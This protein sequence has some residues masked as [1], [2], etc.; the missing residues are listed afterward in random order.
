MVGLRDEAC[1][2][3]PPFVA[4]WPVPV[5]ERS[6]PFGRCKQI[7]STRQQHVKKSRPSFISRATTRPLVMK[8]E[9]EFFQALSQL[10]LF[11]LRSIISGQ[12]CTRH[13]S[14]GRVRHPRHQQ[15]NDAQQAQTG[16]EPRPRPK[17][18]STSPCM[19]TAANVM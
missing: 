15:H 6:S 18:S 12:H 11:D 9:H 2:L 19:A 14:S 1:S 17:D 10:P 5:E 8:F 13:N 16:S 7:D 3:T 4:Q